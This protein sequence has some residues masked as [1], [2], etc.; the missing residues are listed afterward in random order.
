MTPPTHTQERLLLEADT[1]DELHKRLACIDV[2]VAP[3]G[4]QRLKDHVETYAI[5]R[6]LGTLPHAL[7]CFPL[8]LIK[9]ERPDFLIR[10]G[11]REIGVEHTE[12]VPQNAA[13]EAALRAQGHGSGWHFLQPS[14]IGD[15]LKTSGEL[16]ADI[17]ANRPGPGWAGDAV[18]RSWAEAMAHFVDE[19]LAT[20][21]RPGFTLFAENWLLI[22]DNWPAPQLAREKALSLLQVGLQPRDPW[23]VFNHILILDEN[24]LLEI[25]AQNALF[26]AVHHGRR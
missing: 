19:K 5:V 8:Q 10:C 11:S 7:G 9:R 26:H 3:R 18:E 15:P 22:Y 23:R 16:L 12:A 13:K 24:V 1:F 2:V 25:T 21:G 17:R 6:V 14:S 20:A 4:P